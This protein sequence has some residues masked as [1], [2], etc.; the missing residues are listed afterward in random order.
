M[1]KL[2]LSTTFDGDNSIKQEL[3]L[4]LKKGVV[5]L[6]YFLQSLV[7]SEILL[8]QEGNYPM[9]YRNPRRFLHTFQIIFSVHTL[10][11]NVKS[12]TQNVDRTNQNP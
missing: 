3:L 1:G 12:T 11:L 9:P 4:N 6:K 5:F 8:T 2:A 7:F 10:C